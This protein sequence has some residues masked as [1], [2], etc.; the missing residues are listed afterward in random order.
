[1]AGYNGGR[2]DVPNFSI[3]TIWGLARSPELMLDKENLYSVISR[4]TGKDSMRKLTQKEI[5]KVCSAL[6]KLKDA[7]KGKRTDTGG[8]GLTTRQRKKIYTLTE[9]LGWNDNNSRINGFVK[10]MFKCERLEWLNN[11]QCGKLVEMLKSMVDR[12]A[13]KKG[14]DSKDAST[15]ST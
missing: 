13:S 14:S 9:E 1:M 2:A 15:T 3:K 10:K 12:Q 6:F 8:N 5:D 11:A 7:T 4:E